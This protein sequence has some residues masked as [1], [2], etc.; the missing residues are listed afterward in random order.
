MFVDNKYS[1]HSTNRLKK[2]DLARFI[3]EA[4]E[5]TKYLAEDEFRSLPDPDLYYKGEEKDLR[6]LDPEFENIDPQ[7]KLTLRLLRKKKH[8]GKMNG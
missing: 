5:G 1:T 8:W 2:E 3:E 6:T 4:I 7:K